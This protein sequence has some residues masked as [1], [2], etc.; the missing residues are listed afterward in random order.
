[1]IP[2]DPSFCDQSP[3]RLQSLL[4]AVELAPEPSF[5]LIPVEFPLAC[6]IQTS[7][8]NYSREESESGSKASEER[9][10]V[11]SALEWG[12]TPLKGFVPFCLNFT[13]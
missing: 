12:L 10:V 6:G 13:S 4:R 5:L 1:M 11:A 2:S 8:P 7:S 3:Q 9:E